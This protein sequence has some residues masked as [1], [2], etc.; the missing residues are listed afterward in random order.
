MKKLP[1]FERVTHLLRYSPQS[2]N[3][4]WRV[5]AGRQK[6]GSVAG[7]PDG[8]D[9]TNVS[10]DGQTY[11]AHRIAWLL[12]FGHPPVDQLDHI[13]GIRSD[14]RLINLR[15]A[16]HLQNCANSRSR[17]KCGYK[18][19][20]YD[21]KR[22]KFFVSIKINGRQKNLGRYN[23]ARQAARVYD[24]AALREWGEYAQLN[25]PVGGVP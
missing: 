17:S 3:L 18:G 5:S 4:F 22:A 8:D 14:N 11:K 25:F 15:S 7:F 20:S 23:N 9:Y 24:R 10:I 12:Y 6:A 19:V 1:A 2:G 16:T 21:P 13:N